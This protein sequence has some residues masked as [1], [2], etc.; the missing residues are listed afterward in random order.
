MSIDQFLSNDQHWNLFRT[1]DDLQD[2]TTG[3]RLLVRAGRTETVSSYLNKRLAQIGVKYVMSIPGDYIAEWVE[4]LD[5]SEISAG[6]VRVHPN[7]EMC[8][9]YAADGYGRAANGRV[10]CIACTYGV[11][12]LNAA[13]AVAGALVE[14]VP[15]VVINGSP[16]VAQFDAQ[17]DLGILWHHMVDG[18]HTDLRIFQGITTMAVRIDNPATA[19]A[20]IDAALVACITESKP[21]YIEIALQIEA[22][23]CEPV[24][25]TPLRRAPR[26]QSTQVLTAAVDAAMYHLSAAKRLVVLGGVE[27]AR[28]G[29]QQKFVELLKLLEAP[30]VSDLLGKTILSEY[31]DDIRFSGVY[32]GRNSQPNVADLVKKADVILAIGSRDTDFN[33][34]GLASADFQ[35]GP[36]D[37]AFPSAVRV[38]ARADAAWVAGTN[39][40]WGNVD[41]GAFLDALI[42]RVEQFGSQLQR[43]FPGLESGTPWDIPAPGQYAGSASVTWDS[44]KSL[45]QHQL[46]DRY[47][48]ADAP[49]VLADTGLTFYSL[50]NLKLPESGYIGQLAWGAIGY[51]VGA[52]YGAKLANREVGRAHRRAISV[53]GDGAFSESVNA[54]GTIAQLGLDSVIF[55]MVNGVF[56]I[57]QW[58]INANAFAADAPPPHF[59]PLTSVPQSK[60][61]DYV[62][63][64]EGFGGVGYLARTNEEL[65]TVLDK[66]HGGIPTNPTT[67]QP[68]FTL[69]AVALPA[70][71][72]PSNTRWKVKPS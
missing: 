64:A 51:T 14:S 29:L 41:L 68:T 6:L 9:T 32:N 48:E 45:F 5:D 20:L 63:L 4:T 8:A 22:C 7:N 23:P 61:W 43:P 46:L 40:Y 65:S 70:K 19:P 39:R 1:P 28:Y 36:G 3:N 13:Q 67:G 44:F 71:D 33:F 15:L 49:V 52:N 21:V 50:N 57:E 26:P 11:G 54:L 24:P 18:S 53:C 34:A 38:V 55:V 56:A 47:Q 10:G 25:D 35:P 16:S 30:Y 42:A 59:S 69:V 58:L 27:I 17:R 37:D 2:A 31:R 66:I 72:L 12:S 62:K 60:I